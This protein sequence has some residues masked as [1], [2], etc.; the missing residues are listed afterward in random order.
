[1]KGEY[2]VEGRVSP[3]FKNTVS[4]RQRQVLSLDGGELPPAPSMCQVQAGALPRPF[5]CGEQGGTRFNSETTFRFLRPRESLVF[6]GRDF[7]CKLK[8]RRADPRPS[9]AVAPKAGALFPSSAVAGGGIS[10]QCCGRRGG[11]A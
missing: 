1:M 2:F 3:A 9:C 8:R 4:P 7:T 6:S 5:Q 10:Q 11:R